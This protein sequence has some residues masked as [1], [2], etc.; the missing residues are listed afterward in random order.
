MDEIRDGICINCGAHKM[1]H[2]YKHPHLCPLDGVEAPVGKPQEWQDSYFE[3][4]VSFGT[5]AE[6]VMDAI[7]QSNIGDN[8]IIHNSD[9]SINCI[10]TIKCKERPECI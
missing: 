9:G 8:V 4:A 7:R 3:T 6:A 2:H 5:R 10:I 1:L